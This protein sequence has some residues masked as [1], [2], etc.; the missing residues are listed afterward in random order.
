MRGGDEQ[1]LQQRDA[2]ALLLGCRLASAIV[3][4]YLLYAA[5]L[6][7]WPLLILVGVFYLFDWTW[8]EL[9]SA[10]SADDYGKCVAVRWCEGKP[11]SCLLDTEHTGPHVWCCLAY[12][13]SEDA[14]DDET[15]AVRD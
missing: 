1:P 8:R 3:G 15:T 5:Q 14:S 4:L 2:H 7:G 11:H 10:V 13:G 12:E 9:D 6:T